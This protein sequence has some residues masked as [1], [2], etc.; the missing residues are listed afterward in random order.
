MTEQLFKPEENELIFMNSAKKYNVSSGEIMVGVEFE[1]PEFKDAFE[2]RI[3][4]HHYKFTELK[5]NDPLLKILIWDS[6]L[7]T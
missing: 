7:S 4:T 3:Q 6:K 2:E 1:S 5:P